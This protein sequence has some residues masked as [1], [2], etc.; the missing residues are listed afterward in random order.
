MSDKKDNVLNESYRPTILQ[1]G[2][3]YKPIRTGN[4]PKKIIPPKGGTG[5]RIIE[6]KVV[7][8]S[9]EQKKN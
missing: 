4:I 6:L 2:N 9:T 5:A 1:I 7:T 3:S 8:G